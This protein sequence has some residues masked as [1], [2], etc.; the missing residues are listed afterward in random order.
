MQS[1][2]ADSLLWDRITSPNSSISAEARAAVSRISFRS[3][4][5]NRP[6]HRMLE[7]ANSEASRSFK[8]LLVVAGRSRRMAV[9]SHKVELQRLVA[10]RATSLPSE[11][12]DTFGDVASAFVVAG[13]NA[14]LIV[15]Q[16]TLS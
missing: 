2:T 8:P 11:V 13:G 3:E 6:L 7:L 4:S 12:S 14:S 1:N 10:D 16:A 15:T 5:A 9:E